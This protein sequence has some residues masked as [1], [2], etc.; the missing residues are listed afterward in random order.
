MILFDLT[1]EGDEVLLFIY[2][3]KYFL[4]CDRLDL[5]ANWAIGNLKYLTT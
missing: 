2:C 1:M 3:F 4:D 5:L